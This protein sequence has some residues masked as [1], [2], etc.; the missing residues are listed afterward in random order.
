MSER[1]N[2]NNNNNNNKAN[3]SKDYNI[4]HYWYFWEKGFKSKP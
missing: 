2:N 3:T 4:C 1:N